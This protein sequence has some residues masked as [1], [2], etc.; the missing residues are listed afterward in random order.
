[1]EKILSIYCDFDGTITK[2]DT[3]NTFFEKF[4]S[5][6]WLEYEQL[7][8]DGKITS[9]ENAVKQ[10]ALLENISAVEF[11]NYIESIE[12]DDYFIEFIKFAKLNNIKF[13]ILSDGFDLF[14]EKTLEK[15]NLKDIPYYANH[16]IYENNSF[17]IAF[18]YHNKSCDIGAGMCKC[19]KVKEKNFCYI[20][21]G[22]SDLCI[23]KKAD[24]LF[25]TKN[26]QK[27]CTK[28]EIKHIQF[29]TFKDI[30]R[31]FNNGSVMLQK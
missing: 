25:A 18:P 17:K 7:W 29:T 19:E 14:I 1:M 6:K 15:Y 28:N 22:T 20:G 26:L 13:T 3:V 23:A 9:Q 11:N 12:I 10:V 16:L 24:I 30:L 31:S 8:I 27:Y 2:N 21:D 5:K 4:A